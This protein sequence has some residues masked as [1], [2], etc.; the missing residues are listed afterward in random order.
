MI[1]FCR[2]FFIFPL[3]NP[4]LGYTYIV[5]IYIHTYIYTYWEH[6]WILLKSSSS[7]FVRMDL[8]YS[9]FFDIHMLNLRSCPSWG[10][11]NRLGIWL[12]AT[13][14]EIWWISMKSTSHGIAIQNWPIS[15]VDLPIKVVV[16]HIGFVDLLRLEVLVGRRQRRWSC[17]GALSSLKKRDGLVKLFWKSQITVKVCKSC[18]YGWLHRLNQKLQVSVKLGS[19]QKSRFG[20]LKKWTANTHVSHLFFAPPPRLWQ[21]AAFLLWHDKLVLVAD[22]GFQPCFVALFEDKLWTSMNPD[23]MPRPNALEMGRNSRP[24]RPRAKSTTMFAIWLYDF[25]EKWSVLSKPHFYPRIEMSHGWNW[26]AKSWDF[27]SL[28]PIIS[29][30]LRLH[31]SFWPRKIHQNPKI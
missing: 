19:G 31:S 9:V 16:F 12:P 17:R 5:C 13:S 29:N 24:Q 30:H 4:L 26:L 14:I 22:N 1:G 3:E 18:K 10:A 27:R 23:P 8:V 28:K 6:F 15:L 20:I 25:T 2:C 11:I 21:V 7:K